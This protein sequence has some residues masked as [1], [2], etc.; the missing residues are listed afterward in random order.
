MLQELARLR[1][2]MN[3]N[4]CRD[5]PSDPKRDKDLLYSLLEDMDLDFSLTNQTIL[6]HKK[7][8]M[9][10][11]HLNNTDVYF[12]PS[13]CL[14]CN[15]ICDHRTRHI[16][17]VRHDESNRGWDNIGLTSLDLLLLSKAIALENDLIPLHV[18]NQITQNL[19]CHRSES[20]MN[21]TITQLRDEM[22]RELNPLEGSMRQAHQLPE[23]PIGLRVALHQELRDLFRR[24][25]NRRPNS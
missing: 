24:P 5:P 20:H 25:R 16:C 1:D 21:H 22:L 14:I 6:I 17:I 12:I 19:Y 13:L 18:I 3:G 4:N 7:Y 23:N 2:I 15:A 11:I 10:E 8:G 9:F